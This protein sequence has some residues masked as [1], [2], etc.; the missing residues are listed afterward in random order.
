MPRLVEGALMA[1]KRPAKQ[2]PNRLGIVI[3]APVV[4]LLLWLTWPSP[5]QLDAFNCNPK[6]VFGSLSARIYGER[7][8]RAQLAD[9]QAQAIRSEGWDA[10]RAQRKLEEQSGIAM[11]RE[12]SAE[13]YIAHPELAPSPAQQA[14]RLRDAADA[15]EERESDQI[16]SDFFMREAAA[17]RRCEAAILAG[18]PEP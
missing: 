15:I 9:V 2:A 8:W 5:G 1:A 14:Q 3:A 17:A 16:V 4:V 13:L 10:Y 7:F 18:R 6:S 12:A 11:A